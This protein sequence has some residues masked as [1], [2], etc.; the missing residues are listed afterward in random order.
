VTS[1][2]R[3]L[4]LRSTERWVVPP[5]QSH[6]PEQQ[7]ALAL[8]SLTSHQEAGSDPPDLSLG[9]KEGKIR[10]KLYY[11]TFLTKLEAGLIF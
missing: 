4:D 1:F 9:G 10:L 8:V 2:Q 5:R 11:K 6:L 3:F 7:L